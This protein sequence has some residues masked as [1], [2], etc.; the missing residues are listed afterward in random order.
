M[1]PL[2][3][4]R[5]YGAAA[6]LKHLKA[7]QS[8]APG[9][10]QAEDI[11]FIHRMRVASRRLRA[12]LPLFIDCFPKKQSDRWLNQIKSITRALG[13]ARDADVQLELLKELDEAATDPRVRPGLRR[14]S[15]RIAQERAGHQTAVNAALDA[16]DRAN[17]YT[18]MEAALQALDPL[19]LPGT[20][21]PHQLFL[22][23][24]AALSDRLDEFLAY[25][26]YVDQPACVAELHAMRIAAKQ[27]RYTIEIFAPLYPGELAPQ[28]QAIKACQELLGDLHD[29]DVWTTLLPQFIAQER[30]RVITFYGH[31]NPF[32]PLIP[33]LTYF[34]ENRTQVRGQK[35]LA[36][37]EYWQTLQIEDPWSQLRKIVLL[38]IHRA[39][40]PPAAVWQPDESAGG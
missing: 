23:A 20:P 34:Q 17:F 27:L 26:P 12:A 32:H 24:A 8:E 36:F 16:L 25:E 5:S 14:L 40:F 28:M 29:C 13:A 10:R 4:T 37:R 21:Y 38:P 7:L 15:L 31:I 33:G 18:D 1:K 19:L 3:Q 6:L 2:R 22:R 30:Q 39:V 9:V 11:E 35:Y